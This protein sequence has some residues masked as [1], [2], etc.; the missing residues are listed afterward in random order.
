[1]IDQSKA[2]A[3]GHLINRIAGTEGVAAEL[4]KKLA[5]NLYAIHMGFKLGE[6]FVSSKALA[7]GLRESCKFITALLFHIQGTEFEGEGE[8]LE[9]TRTILADKA[10]EI[11]NA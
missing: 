2:P 5:T 3:T 1:M 8:L 10:T 11:E 9:Y 4:A 7:V 6:N